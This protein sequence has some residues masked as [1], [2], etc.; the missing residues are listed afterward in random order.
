MTKTPTVIATLL[1][2]GLPIALLATAPGAAASDLPW[3][4]VPKDLQTVLPLPREA[5][6]PDYGLVLHRSGGFF[7]PYVVGYT[8]VAG[9]FPALCVSVWKET[10]GVAGL[11]KTWTNHGQTP[12]DTFVTAYCPDY[13][14]LP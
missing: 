9:T 5:C 7:V 3:N 8:C 10:N 1:L 14:W 4:V 6:T 12:P 11:Q 2:A 13:S